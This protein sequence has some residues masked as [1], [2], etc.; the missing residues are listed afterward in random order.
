M[1]DRPAFDA[2]YCQMSSPKPDILSFSFVWFKIRCFPLAQRVVM[3]SKYKFSKS[4]F[5][6]YGLISA[7]SINMAYFPYLYY[8]SV[9]YVF[10]KSNT[11][12]HQI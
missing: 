6:R 11:R 4:V 3:A 9:R 8:C 5:C 10:I 1:L 7:A 12:M 2:I